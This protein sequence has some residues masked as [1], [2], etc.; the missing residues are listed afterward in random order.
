MPVNM[1]LNHIHKL[2]FI[3][4]GEGGVKERP[5]NNSISRTHEL[6]AKSY[7]DPEDVTVNLSLE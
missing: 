3:V 1:F 2:M 6:A 5:H 4:M 7:C